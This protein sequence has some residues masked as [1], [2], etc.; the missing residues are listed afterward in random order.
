MTAIAG[1]S[2]YYNTA[3]Y[4]NQRGS[5]VEAPNLLGTASSTS[6]LDAG[7]QNTGIGLS[8]TARSINNSF[9]SQTSSSFNQ[10][11]SLNG[12][13]FGT[14]E[15]LQQEILAIRSRIADS[16]LGDATVSD[17]YGRGDA[18]VDIEA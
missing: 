16:R 8:G 15:T 5:V 2:R 10:I 3:V 1:S 14:T 4:A 13:E 11:F 6:L 12:V 18:G 17:P 9:L 7:R